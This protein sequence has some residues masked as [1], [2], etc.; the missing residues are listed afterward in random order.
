MIRKTKR[1]APTTKRG[2]LPIWKTLVIATAL[3]A[4]HAP[5][6]VWGACGVFVLLIWGY[7][8]WHL[9]NFDEQETEPKWENPPTPT[10]KP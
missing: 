5:E 1:I 6:W 3:Q 9:L 8:I 2:V 10:K 4:F 7:W